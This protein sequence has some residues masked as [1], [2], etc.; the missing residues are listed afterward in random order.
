[1]PKGVITKV[2]QYLDDAGEHLTEI[3]LRNEAIG[4]SVA[5]MVRHVRRLVDAGGGDLAPIQGIIAATSRIAEAQRVIGVSISCTRIACQ[6]VREAPAVRRHRRNAWDGTS[7]R[8]HG[9]DRRRVQRETAE[10]VA[11]AVAA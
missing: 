8:R 1:M 3:A 5:D 9:Y 2:D 10:L 11:E 6:E 4:E 7:E